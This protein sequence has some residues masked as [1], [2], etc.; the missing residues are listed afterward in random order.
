MTGGYDTSLWCL[1]ELY[2][3]VLLPE[4]KKI[5]VPMLLE[6]EDDINQQKGGKWL[7][8]M[9]KAH[10]YFKPV[11]IDAMIKDLKDKVAM[12]S[13]CLLSLL[14]VITQAVDMIISCTA[15]GGPWQCLHNI[16]GKQ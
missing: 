2:Y 3:A 7:K 14:V 1:R 6:K 10:K 9:G 15:A 13:A 12:F 11:E 5:I 4:P 8:R 16:T